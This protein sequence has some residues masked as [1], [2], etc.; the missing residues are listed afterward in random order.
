MAGCLLFILAWFMP[1]RCHAEPYQVNQPVPPTAS[2]RPATLNDGITKLDWL[3][4]PNVKKPTAY[5][6]D[7]QA[8][9]GLQ[10]LATGQ[11]QAAETHCKN[12]LA[13]DPANSDAAYCLGVAYQHKAEQA[14]MAAYK[15]TLQ[16]EAIQ[17]W[18][19]ALRQN[20]K[21]ALA[22]VRLGEQYRALGQADSSKTMAAKAYLLMPTHPEVLELIG[23]LL[24]DDGQPAQALPYLTQRQQGK[25]NAAMFLLNGRYF[26]AIGDPDASRVAY[27]KAQLQGEQSLDPV[28][29]M[30]AS[31]AA[32]GLGQWAYAAG[33]IPMAAEHFATSTA[34]W[35]G[36]AQA[37]QARGLV[38]EQLG[39]PE[40]A[41]TTY[42]Q[43]RQLLASPL[44]KDYKALGIRAALLASQ[45][46]KPQDS[47]TLFAHLQRFYPDDPGIREG[48]A[49]AYQQQALAP[50][51]TALPSL[52]ATDN[53]L[54][55]L[56]QS[57]ALAPTNVSAR[58]IALKKRAERTALMDQQAAQKAQANEQAWQA[59]QMAYA[60]AKKYH[61]ETTP[62]PKLPKGT[63]PVPVP[64][65][66]AHTWP[67]DKPSTWENAHLSAAIDQGEQL[68]SQFD[69]HGAYARLENALAI[70]T[71][72]E[73]RLQLADMVLTMG[74]PELALKA[75]QKNTASGVTASATT[76]GLAQIQREIAAADAACQQGQALLE[77]KDWPKAV[78]AF[79]Q[80]LQHQRMMPQ[81]HEGLA[82]AFH[83][84]KLEDEANRH[85]YIA[86]G[87]YPEGTKPYEALRKAFERNL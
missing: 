34:L 22:M 15:T 79:A 69:Y 57:L 59:Q 44:D 50:T 38:A 67:S 84:L 72:P 46:G 75:I 87:F 53:T 64:W 47:A 54:A 42:Q 70:A 55:L 41:Y 40:A 31:E 58:R 76:K 85:R 14:N 63:L 61:Q 80:A 82:L 19:S 1:L 4:P 45:M 71:R 77:A 39:Q 23:H 73:D 21:D 68:L 27:E 66:L 25:R 62:L 7:R 8:M 18:L 37:W 51:K 43:A 49:Q 13:S 6:R 12:L 56:E 24:L 65:S 11:T 16:H 78:Q 2:Q 5:P 3:P 60:E 20:P 26:Q 32:F 33:E 48:L 52:L 35:P 36:N 28:E 17:Q 29:K 83:K 9:V 10:L 86:L 81:A 30:A 74:F